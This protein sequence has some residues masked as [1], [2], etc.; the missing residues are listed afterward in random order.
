MTHLLLPL[1][2]SLLF[3]GGMIFAKRASLAGI[4]PLTFLFV[5]NLCAC[6]AFSF[7]WM[8]GGELPSA[9]MWWQPVVIAGLYLIGLTFTF[10]AIQMGD[11]S[12]ATPVFGIKVILVALL[13]T[14]VEVNPP[15]V[16]IWLAA[17]LA[18][19]GI[20]LIQWTGEGERHHLVLTIV[21]AVLSATSF[22]TFDISVQRCAPVWGAGRLL[23]AIY[24]TVGVASLVLVP[25]V[26]WS[27][28]RRVEIQKLVFPGAMLVALQAVCIVLAVG[29]FGDAA[30][31]NVVYALRGLWGVGLAWLAARIW[32]G[33]EANLSRSTL[34]TRFLGAAVLTAAVVVVIVAGD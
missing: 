23:P 13:L 31:V 7:L 12:V 11:V 29:M 28:L 9:D 18:T 20:A 10:L 2:A 30:R 1:L 16:S 19:L 6:G 21:F 15:G 8:L 3:V 5:S 24:W 26:Q 33:R 14:A 25:W 32:G 22:A 17:L 4:G 27:D 34:L